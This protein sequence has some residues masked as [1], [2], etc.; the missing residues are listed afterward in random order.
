MMG[1][2]TVAKRL[3]LGFG[4]IVS[5]MVLISVVGNH[6]VG[7]IDRTLTSVNE[8]ASL[9]QRY[10]INFRGSVH[11]RAIAV[12]DV[13]L[14]NS[15]SALR[16]QL[17]S[18]DELA[19][20]YRDNAADMAQ[21]FGDQGA[22]DQEQR[23]L[24]AIEAIEQRTLAL[25]AELLELRRANNPEQ[26]RQFLLEQVSP[27]Y[28][29]WL[30][31]VN[32]FIDY[33]E[34]SVASDLDEVRAAA[35]GFNITILSITGF[36]VLLSVLI[37]LVIIRKL[38]RVL[39]AEPEEVASVIRNL[40]DGELDQTLT[41]RY[42]DSVMG[43]L[44]DTIEQLTG[45]ISEVRSAS[46]ALSAASSQLER[47]SDNNSKQIRMQ[48]AEAEQMAAA[49]NQM[50]A[51]VN[52]VAGYAAG[53]AT[54]TRKAD[55]EVETGNL[56]VQ[57]TAASITELANKLEEAAA[58]VNRVSQDSGNIEKIIE[59]ISGIAEQTNLLALNAAIEAARAGTHGRGFAVVADEVRSLAS[60][61]QDSTREI[62]DMIGRLQAGAGE[63]A[64]E[65]QSSRERARV[66]VE[67]TAEAESALV[68][69]REEVSS[70]NDMNAQ[71]ASAAEEQSAVAEE[72]N[73]NIAKIH[74][75]TLETSAGSEQV[76]SSSRDLAVLAGQLRSR[77]SVFQF[78]N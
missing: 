56:V 77:V 38:K 43:A 17:R 25:T 47:T 5:L 12:R 44:V 32:A 10:A 26:S 57:Q 62:Q 73:R 61:T 41:T 15:D 39:G 59:V 20:M 52:E 16:E 78:K 3:A 28:S 18:I 60:R 19:V 69:I 24:G 65:M 55:A 23:L 4:L 21:M 64:S 31:R 76:A 36:A 1:P 6:Q 51:T 72:V 37:A 7:F 48:A 40:A 54:A 2:F 42:P 74:D 13:V 11:D 58:S 63:A 35:S 46:E 49:V 27:A 45:I 29:E 14:V 33:Q 53:A 71:I 9:K 66:T 75:S 22:T 67:K 8:G 50:A 34:N 68:R 70:I 30:G